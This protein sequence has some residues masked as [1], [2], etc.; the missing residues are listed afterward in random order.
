VKT[1]KQEIKIKKCSNPYKVLKHFHCVRKMFKSAGNP[2]KRIFIIL[3]KIFINIAQFF[4]R[5]RKAILFIIAVVL[6]N[7]ILTFLIVSL[8]NSY[9]PNGD[10]RS[11]PTVGA[12]TLQ[13]LEI[14]GGDIKVEGENVYVDWGDLT[15]GASKNA[16]FYVKST[17]NVDVELGLNVTDWDPIGIEEY[18][19]ISWDYNGTLLSPTQEI[20]V[21][22]NLH[23]A[24]DGDF[25]DFLVTNEV[26]AFGFNMTI[27]A[28]GV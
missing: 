10:D 6:V 19:T 17:S 23:V 7:I 12:I 9:A 26:T 21:V 2:I 8:F 15:L 27:Y 20:P 5:K 1:E 28:T 22:V 16:S 11:I 4:Y 18:L 14:Y 13:G 24:S 25:I 3:K